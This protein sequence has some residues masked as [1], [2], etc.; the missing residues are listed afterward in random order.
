[1]SVYKQQIVI[2][3]EFTPTPKHLRKKG[4]RNEIIEI[5]AV[6]LDAFG[7]E[8]DTFC[9]CVRPVVAKGISPDVRKLTG[10]DESHVRE[11]RTFEEVLADFAEWIGDAPSRIVAW[12]KND[13]DQIDAECAFK[14]I[15]RPRQLSKWLDLQA[16]YPRLLGVANGKPM[17]LR[18][19]AEWCGV[20][21]D[22]KSSHRALY[23]AQITAEFMRQAISG[24][25]RQQKAVLNESITRGPVERATASLGSMCAGL[26]ELLA[27][28]TQ[29]QSPA[30][31]MVA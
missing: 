12:S 29:G 25:Y 22:K 31:A 7:R 2:D 23:D 16:V 6:K 10:I 3:L 9:E 26:S 8:I 20:V 5:G 17:A 18:R 1:M 24:D 21:V 11:A 30:C 13:K 28:M 14:G 19:A 27:Q 4:L 15:A